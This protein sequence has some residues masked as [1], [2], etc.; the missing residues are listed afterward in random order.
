M[1]TRIAIA[2]LCFLVSCSAQ[3]G[4]VGPAGPQGEPGPQGIQGPTGPTG[5]QGPIGGGKYT[6]RNDVYCRTVLATT[7]APVPSARAVA[8]CDG[9]NDLYLAGGCVGEALDTRLT[10]TEP[11]ADNAQPSHVCTW[12]SD[13]PHQ[14]DGGQGFAAKVCCI[15]G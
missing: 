7:P 5:P 13:M 15:K 8:F 2:S 9:V 6:K 10:Q 11:G 4:P 14:L 1:H 12:L 3:P